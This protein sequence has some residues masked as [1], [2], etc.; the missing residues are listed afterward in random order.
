VA[1]QAQ[2]LAA[3]LVAEADTADAALQTAGVSTG[4]FL[5]GKTRLSSRQATSLVFQARRLE[6]LPLACDAVLDGSISMNHAQAVS[7]AMTQM[8]TSFTVEQKTRAES[9]LVTLA[10]RATPDDVV[11]AAPRIAEQVDPVDANNRELARLARERE[12]AWSSRSLTFGRDAGS[13]T[14]RGSLPLVEG[15]TL[16]T[17]VT[18]YASQI[19]RNAAER[20]SGGEPVMLWQRQA[21]ALVRLCVD[22][23]HHRGAPALGGDRPTVIVTLNFDKL[24]AGAADAGVLPDGQPLSAGDLRRLCCDANLIPTVLG[25]A[26]EPLDVGRTHRFVTPAIRTAVTLRDSHCVFPGC[27]V[28]AALCDVH[29]IKPW[30]AGGTT[31][32]ANLVLLCPHHHALIEPDR[33]TARN[34]WQITVQAD[35]HPVFTPPTR[36]PTPT[37]ELTHHTRPPPTTNT[38]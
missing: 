8:P 27:D 38:H 37:T 36:H 23:K 1:S 5:A 17:L 19:R 15:E 9:L 22:A 25:G 3:I 31:S 16:R 33:N 12:V 32:L 35:G 21:D 10:G 11:R 30:W 28:P 29:H 14:F 7:R 24:L 20:A 34:Q 2:G 13:V 6:T 18:A 4:S 26:S